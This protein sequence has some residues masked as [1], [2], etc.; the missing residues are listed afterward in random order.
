MPEFLSSMPLSFKNREGNV[1]VL[2]LFILCLTLNVSYIINLFGKVDPLSYI[3][4]RISRDQYVSKYIPE[5]PALKFINENLALDSKILCIDLGRRG[6]Y[7]DRK[8]FF[9]EGF[10]SS[11]ISKGQ[12]KEEILSGF[13]KKGITHIL[14]FY[15]IFDK[16]VKNNYS[17]DKQELVKAFFRDCTVS[18]FY[19][20]GVGLHVLKTDIL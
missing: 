4:G 19:K 13:Q 1:I 10:L 5:Y 6:Y 2:I 11:I 9:D 15:P 17:K 12:D 20:N 7:C 3:S 14:V 8:Y 18:A 16:W